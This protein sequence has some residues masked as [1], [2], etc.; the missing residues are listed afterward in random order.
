MADSVDTHT[1]CDIHYLFLDMANAS[2]DED[3][4]DKCVSMALFARD[5]ALE[6]PSTSLADVKAKLEMLTEDAGCGLVEVEGLAFIMRDL[7]TL[8][9]IVQ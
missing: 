3:V 8:I 7:D 4:N 9:G 1:I 2:A 6:T 5:V